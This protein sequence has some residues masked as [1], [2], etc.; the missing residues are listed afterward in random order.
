MFTRIDCGAGRPA[1]GE[2]DMRRAYLE[3]KVRVNLRSFLHHFRLG[4][5]FEPLEFWLESGINALQERLL[6]VCLASGLSTGKSVLV[7]NFIHRLLE[8]ALIPSSTRE[9]AVYHPVESLVN[10][11]VIHR[12][13]DNFLNSGP[14]KTRV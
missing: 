8:V 5:R 9:T 6:I 4:S 13:V 14:C 12:A 7:D 3:P 10:L 11:R 1:R 2:I